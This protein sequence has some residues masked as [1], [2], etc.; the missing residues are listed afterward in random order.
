MIR[1]RIRVRVQ[2]RA[3]ERAKVRSFVVGA[4]SHI[5]VGLKRVG[6]TVR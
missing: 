3:R 6:V 2:V 1:V 5:T 4:W